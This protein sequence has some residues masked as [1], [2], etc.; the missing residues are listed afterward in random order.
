LVKNCLKFAFL[1]H[2]LSKFTF[3]T[4]KTFKNH[5]SSPQNK[6]HIYNLKISKNHTSSPQKHPK[7][8]FLV[9]KPTQKTINAQKFQYFDPLCLHNL[10]FSCY[11]AILNQHILHSRV[12][13]L[14]EYASTPPTLVFNSRFGR[15]FGPT[16][17]V[18]S[19]F[20]A[21]DYWIFYR[22]RIYGLWK[23]FRT[24]SYRTSKFRSRSKNILIFCIF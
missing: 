11:C 4:S 5:T 8:T 17:F 1:G 2:I 19:V 12:I 16:F 22:V 7:L 18:A 21:C 13:S 14:E 23:F 3:I 10:I 15:P 24:I 9:H 6:T 20:L